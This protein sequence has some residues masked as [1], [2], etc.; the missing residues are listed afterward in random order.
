MVGWH[1]WL[2]GHGFGWTPRVG[3]GQGGLVCCGS[4]VCKGS[5]RSER[6]NWN[7][8]LSWPEP[9]TTS[10]ADMALAKT[11]PLIVALGPR[12]LGLE[13]CSSSSRTSQVQALFPVF[14]RLSGVGMACVYHLDQ[15]L[16]CLLPWQTG[17]IDHARQVHTALQA[18]ASNQLVLAHEVKPFYHLC[19]SDIGEMKWWPCEARI[20]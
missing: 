9:L 16:P 17:R 15:H 8:Y 10:G 11:T 18:A 14:I 19:K 7:E 12:E 4:W 5:D 1:R 20:R 3:D 13:R 2:N 6:L